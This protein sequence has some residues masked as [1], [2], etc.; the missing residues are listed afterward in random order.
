M[1]ID[2]SGKNISKNVVATV[3]QVLVSG[4][5]F[6][7]LYRYLYDH[8]GV[9]QIGVWALVLASTSISRIG[10]LGLTAGVV[11]FVAQALGRN[12][13][14]RAADVVQTIALTLGVFMAVLLAACY[15]LFVLALSY[16][17]PAEGFP[18]ALTI[19]PYALVSLWVTVVVSV[20]SGGLDG[21]MRMDLRSLLMTLFHLVYL[22]LAILLV[23]KYGLEGVAMAQLIQS[24]GL[25]I[26]L[27]WGLRRQ[28]KVLP[29]VPLH[30][31]F[32][33]LKDMFRYGVN[34][35]IITIMN[36]L[37]DPMV[38]AMM[39][40][41]GGLEVLGY[42]QMA[43]GLIL[44]GRGLIVEA[45]RV[46]VPAIATLKES[47]AGSERQLFNTSYR[48]MFYVSILFY[49]AMGSSIT[50]ISMLWLG[51]YHATF[52][53]FA[54]LL[55][56]AWFVNTLISPAY[57]SNLGTGLLR[58]NMIAHALIGLFT[59]LAG[60]VL[61]EYY[62]GIGVVISVVIG[63]IIGSV[64]LLLNYLNK[65][66]LKWAAFIVPQKMKLLMIF[67]VIAIT[68]SNY[69]RDSQS[70]LTT[71][72]GL[73]SLCVCCLLVIGWKNPARKFLLQRIK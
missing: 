28:L 48:L 37:F 34:F 26:M 63:L 9:E 22:G 7:V 36:M 30:W 23:P 68:I 57:F 53:Q 27:W 3:S 39:S 10:E 2:V 25:L 20:F 31:N 56:L 47:S 41:F 66:E 32:P 29:V 4:V 11:K 54:L 40:K 58:P 19:L 33:V 73:T 59:P 70:A 16:F 12:D 62:G 44:R 71:V 14:Q 67:A 65:N 52:I 55:N 45:S 61:G 51:H 21:C 64:Y 35:Q 13:A 1:S 69:G 5:V 17:L 49:G 18:I 43:N 24:I 15:P 72:I 50:M 46:L 6:F 38:K 42:Y 60:W 8:L